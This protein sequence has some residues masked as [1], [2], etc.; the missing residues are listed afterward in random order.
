MRIDNFNSGKSSLVLTLLR[1]LEIRRGTVRVDDIDIF[2]LP[3]Q[4]VRRSLTTLPQDPVTLTGTVRNNLDPEGRL[5]TDSPD[6]EA[7]LAKVGIWSIVS[8]RGGLDT[9]FRSMGLSTE[10]KQLFCLA[11]ALLHKSKLILLDEATSSVDMDTDSTIRSLMRT[12]FEDSTVT[13]VVHRLDTVMDHD[14]LVVMKDGG[15]TEVGT[16]RELL[17]RNNSSAW[18]SQESQDH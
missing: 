6:L 7:V 18:T 14:V 1:L 12:E 2:V 13:E 15:I 8:V 5:A 11:R 16:P 10:Q 3:R 9:D 17:T 4:S